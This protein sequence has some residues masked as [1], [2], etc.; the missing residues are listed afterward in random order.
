LRIIVG[1]RFT[2]V[3]RGLI[4]L[5]IFF[6]CVMILSLLCCFF[7]LHWE[8]LVLVILPYCCT[9]GGDDLPVADIYLSLKALKYGGD[10]ALGLTRIKKSP[11]KFL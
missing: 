6:S 2:A 8:Y 4:V 9:A 7:Q 11:K 3:F 5:S 10:A 1:G